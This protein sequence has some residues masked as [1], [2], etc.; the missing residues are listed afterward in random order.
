MTLLAFA[1]AAAAVD[2][3]FPACTAL[4]CKPATRRGCGRMTRQTDRETDGRTLDR[5]INPA[6]HTMRA[7]SIVLPR[8]V[9]SVG[10]YAS[11][12]FN[13]SQGLTRQRLQET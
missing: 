1:A 10:D 9:L 12:D 4:S 3:L 6:R 13:G 8:N 5:F 11:T 2:R 7:L